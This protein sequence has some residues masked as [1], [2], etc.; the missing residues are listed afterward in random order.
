MNPL[1]DFMKTRCVLV[2][3]ILSCHFC[4]KTLKIGWYTDLE[5]HYIL[6]IA[7][8]CCNKMLRK[9]TRA[10]LGNHFWYDCLKNVFYTELHYIIINAM[11][12]ILNHHWSS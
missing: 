4:F 8:K 10:W 9:R 6:R 2:I 7:T 5:R 11:P 3:R 1:M 12:G